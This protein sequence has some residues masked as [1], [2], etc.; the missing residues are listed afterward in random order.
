MRKIALDLGAKKTSF[1]EIDNGKIIKRGT[2]RGLG[3]L[4]KY[5]GA[6]GPKATVAFEACRVGWHLAT[7]L[8][9]LGHEPVMIDTTRVKLLG[10]GL[11]G[12]KTDEIDAELIA[13]ALDQKRLPKAHILSPHRQSIRLQQTVRRSLVE[14][15]AQY[16][17]LTRETVR[18]HGGKV[19][20]GH[21]EHFVERVE[22]AEL[23]EPVRMLVQP[24]VLLVKELS[25]QIAVVEKKL[26]QLC[27]QDQ[28]VTLLSTAPGVSLVVAA[29]FVSVVDEA[30]RFK[31]AHELESYLGLVP[32]EKSSGGKQRLGSISKAGN[33][34]LRSLLVQSAWSVLRQK[35]EDDPLK[36]WGLAIAQKRGKRI[37]VVAVARRLAG[38]LWAMWRNGCV[39]DPQVL[40]AASH[41]GLQRAAQDAQLRSK[42]MQRAEQKLSR[43]KRSWQRLCENEDASPQ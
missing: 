35:D 14:T 20:S 2:M 19:A 5:L 41:A 40:A 30:K 24:W 15:R 22:Q 9:Q 16:M 21:A 26:L 13:H 6:N 33:P 25:K 27:D 3:D 36:K 23:A 8:Q 4:F 18:A 39:Y 17:A 38:I 34:Y 37:A 10:I 43:R 12:R 1:C 28:T 32:Q 31:R 42:A 7:R 29:A 11:H